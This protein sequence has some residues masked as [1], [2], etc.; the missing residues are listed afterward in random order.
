MR[1]RF[2]LLGQCKQSMARVG[3]VLV[4][5]GCTY[6]GQVSDQDSLL[7]TVRTIQP[8]LLVI[9]VQEDPSGLVAS[10]QTIEAEWLCALLL[11]THGTHEGIERFL[12]RS[13]VSTWLPKPIAEEA[14]LPVVTQ[15]IKTF[16]LLAE[17]QREIHRLRRSMDER[18]SLEKAKWLLGR[19]QNL[20]EAEAYEVIRRKSRESRQPMGKIAE[21]IILAADMGIHGE[22]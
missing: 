12:E 9:D 11:L 4:G 17:H 6:A 3:N 19:M 16:R 13:A 1:A 10:L 5:S 21:A 20:S 7:R 14:V 8:D 18:R 22:P 2:L 15:G